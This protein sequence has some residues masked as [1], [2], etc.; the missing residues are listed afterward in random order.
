MTRTAGVGVTSVATVA[1]RLVSAVGIIRSTRVGSVGSRVGSVES[2]QPMIRMLATQNPTDVLCHCTLG[3]LLRITPPSRHETR[4]GTLVFE[5]RDIGPPERCFGARCGIRARG[6]RR[7]PHSLTPEATKRAMPG[8]VVRRGR[9]FDE[10]VGAA[11]QSLGRSKAVAECEL[12]LERGFGRQRGPRGARHVETK[13]QLR[14]L[15]RSAGLPNV[16]QN[17]GIRYVVV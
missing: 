2:L 16:L 4:L 9:R 12:E 5:V 8:G 3:R 17:C 1:I 13:D 14:R 10:S 7:G 11:T 15:S 6:L